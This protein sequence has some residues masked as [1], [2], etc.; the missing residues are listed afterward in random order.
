MLKALEGKTKLEVVDY[1]TERMRQQG[2]VRSTL[3]GSCAYRGE[4]GRV[5]GIGALISAEEY[6]ELGQECGKKGLLTPQG[7][8]RTDIEGLTVASFSPIFPDMIPHE[9]DILM[10]EI[11]W[12]HDGY[13]A[14]DPAGM[15][16]AFK[17]LRERVASGKLSSASNWFRQY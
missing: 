11:Q 9:M 10:R 14:S 4:E 17:K 6:V 15:E 5:C 7:N 16:D 1:V 12:A 3:N 8:L 13:F 2:F